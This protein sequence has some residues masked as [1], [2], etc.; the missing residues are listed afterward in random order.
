M[1]VVL[2]IIIAIVGCYAFQEATGQMEIRRLE[3]AAAQSQ[4]EAE[5][6]RARAESEKASGE[7]ALAEAE[8]EAIKAPALAA[9]AAVRAQSFILTLWGIAAPIAALI[10]LVFMSCGACAMGA[11]LA[12]AQRSIGLTNIVRARVR[13]KYRDAT[14]S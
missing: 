8:G 4:A 7:R 5:L 9:A 12:T 6:A 2:V 3:A 14:R 10:V 13:E 11:L 1:I